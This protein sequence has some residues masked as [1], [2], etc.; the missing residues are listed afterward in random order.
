MCFCD[1]AEVI[2]AGVPGYIS[3]YVP[4]LGRLHPLYTGPSK[5]L[6]YLH[7]GSAPAAA[8]PCKLW[9][10]RFIA[11]CRGRQKLIRWAAILAIA[12]S[13]SLHVDVSTKYL[14][15]HRLDTFA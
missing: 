14:L 1:D 15:H 7:M 2:A 10:V 5:C 9:P 3:T 8:D 13:S 4:S 12:L 11:P 6:V